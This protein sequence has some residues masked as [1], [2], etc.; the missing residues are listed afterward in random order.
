MK[1]SN[2]NYQ[3]RTKYIKKININPFLKWIF[4]KNKYVIPRNTPNNPELPP[5]KILKN[6]ESPKPS[7]DLFTIKRKRSSV[8]PYN[9]VL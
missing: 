1:E 6:V 2:L 3:Q 8:S 5:V 4:L 9:I 7:K